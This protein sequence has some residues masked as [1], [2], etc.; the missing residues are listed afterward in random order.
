MPTVTATPSPI[1]VPRGKRVL[2]V[3]WGRRG[4]LSWMAAELAASLAASGSGDV[5]SY[6]PDNELAPRLAACAPATLP[7]RT[8]SSALGAITGLPR[9]H[10]D[11]RALVASLREAGFGA[12]VVL[13]PHVW[14]PLLAPIVHRAGLRHLVVVHD[15]VG[16]PGDRTGIA[17]RW[18]LREAREADVVVTLSSAVASRLVAD[19]RAPD[20][21]IVVETHPL[22]AYPRVKRS[23]RRGPLRVLFLGRM[24]AYKGLSLLAEAI[25][26]LGRRGLAVDLGV[27][28]SG[29][30][31]GIAPRLRALGATVENRWIDHE[32][33]GGILARY[34]V[35]A[36]PYVEASQSGVALTAFGGGMPVVATPVGGLGEQVRHGVDGLL[37]TEATPAAFADA[38]AR[39]ATDPALLAHLTAGAATHP[40]PSVSSFAAQLKELALG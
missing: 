33:I 17:N 38:L 35:M 3:Y 34:D 31:G 15:A 28:G 4:A 30:L 1:A 11:A 5:L 39:I 10:R 16:H 37:A 19:G 25:E 14:T 6:T 32:E 9:F 27:I 40:G 36:L 21:R 8:F 23:P 2:F 26:L 29:D 7:F 12:V 20:D 18:L 24:M 13:M 22:L